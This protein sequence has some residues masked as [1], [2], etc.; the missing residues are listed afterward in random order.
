MGLLG[1]V[2]AHKMVIHEKKGGGDAHPIEKKEP[3]IVQ[4]KEAA[5]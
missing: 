2:G 5:P 1:S 4:V 3:D